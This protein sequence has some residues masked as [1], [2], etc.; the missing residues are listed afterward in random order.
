MADA[1]LPF[2]LQQLLPEDRPGKVGGPPGNAFE[3]VY[4]GVTDKV[5]EK[6]HSVDPVLGEYIRCEQSTPKPSLDL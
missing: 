4:D 1:K 3:I 6:M 2:L 5:R